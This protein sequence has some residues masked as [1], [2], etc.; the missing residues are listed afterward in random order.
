MILEMKRNVTIKEGNDSGKSLLGMYLE[1]E[2]EKKNRQKQRIHK[3]L[4]RTS[5]VS[6]KPSQAATGQDA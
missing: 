2:H 4:Q 6:A 5:G 1:I 3:L